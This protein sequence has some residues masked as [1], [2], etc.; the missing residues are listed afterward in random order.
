MCM[1]VSWDSHGRVI[2]FRVMH[3]GLRKLQE[4]GKGAGGGGGGRGE[5]ETDY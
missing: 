2:S 3:D 1:C 4:T 5:G